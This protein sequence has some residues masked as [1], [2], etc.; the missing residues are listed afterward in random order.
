[1]PTAIFS[2]FTDI[3]IFLFFFKLLV[4]SNQQSKLKCIPLQSWKIIEKQLLFTVEGVVQKLEP[5]N[6]DVLA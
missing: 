3:Y 1:M 4:L 5:I 6:L 2:S